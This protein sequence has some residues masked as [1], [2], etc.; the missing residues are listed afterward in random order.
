[1]IQD[2][3]RQVNDVGKIG[4]GTWSR[5]RPRPRD[6][7]TRAATAIHEQDARDRLR[8]DNVISAP[9]ASVVLDQRVLKPSYGALPRDAISRAKIDQQIGSMGSVRSG[10][11]F[12]AAHYVANCRS[13]IACV[14][15]SGKPARN[16]PAYPVG[17]G[18]LFENPLALTTLKV[19][20]NSAESDG[21]G[22]GPRPIHRS[23]TVTQVFSRL[24]SVLKREQA[25]LPE[26]GV[27]VEGA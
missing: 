7:G 15:K 26:P 11:E 18:A 20:V 3:G 2:C 13:R 16:G 19:Q 14:P 9:A 4:L 27:G 21:I 1:M 8:I 6:A 24:A 25:V 23:Q 5:R 10:V 17:F 22:V 12:L